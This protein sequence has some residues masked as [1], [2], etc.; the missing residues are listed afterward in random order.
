MIQLFFKRQ[1]NF[2]FSLYR[3]KKGRLR[4]R[5]TGIGARYHQRQ[6]M[7]TRGAINYTYMYIIIHTCNKQTQVNGQTKVKTAPQVIDSCGITRCLATPLHPPP[8]PSHPW[9]LGKNRVLF[10]TT[11]YLKSSMYFSKQPVLNPLL[12]RLCSYICFIILIFRF[13]IF[14][15]KNEDINNKKPT[16][17]DTTCW[18]LVEV[19]WDPRQLIG[20]P[21]ACADTA[22]LQEGN[23]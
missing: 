3:A 2:I 5:N 15:K 10:L 12:Y 11:I 8:P 21:S 23:S 16:F 20:W 4:L 18:W 1:T 19:S 17:L 14:N 22:P 6:E 9:F 7:S 13:S